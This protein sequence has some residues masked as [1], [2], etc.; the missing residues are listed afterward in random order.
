MLE[1][2]GRELDE[3][4]LLTL[5]LAKAHP[6]ASTALVTRNQSRPRWAAFADTLRIGSQTA[7]NLCDE[8]NMDAHEQ[9]RK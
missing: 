3:I 9:V 6:V 8:L 4:R 1:L 7:C 5:A 2:K